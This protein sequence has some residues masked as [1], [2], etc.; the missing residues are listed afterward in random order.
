MKKTA[1]NQNMTEQRLRNDETVNTSSLPLDRKN[2]KERYSDANL[3]QPA[4]TG[5]RQ[6]YDD[7]TGTVENGIG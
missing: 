5:N 2:K 7:N 1:R 6:R 4:S 3:N